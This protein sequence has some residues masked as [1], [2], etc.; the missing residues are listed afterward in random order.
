MYVC[1]N[2]TRPVPD[3]LSGGKG[4]VDVFRLFSGR[5]GAV[6]VLG[7]DQGGTISRAAKSPV[8]VVGTAGNI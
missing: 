4:I 8:D 3:P 7:M 1:R 2:P 5:C 6:A